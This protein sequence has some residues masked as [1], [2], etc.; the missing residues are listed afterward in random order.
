MVKAMHYW[1]PISKR[2][3]GRSKTR[4]EDVVRKDTQKLK[5]P[6]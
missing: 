5:V 2:P 4:W 6:H 1:K 3:V